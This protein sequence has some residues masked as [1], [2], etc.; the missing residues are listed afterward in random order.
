M[1]HELASKVLIWDLGFTLIEPNSFKI[2]RRLGI[3][4]CTLMYMTFGR[5]S[6]SIVSDSMYDVMMNGEEEYVACVPYD[7]E[8]RLM[9]L[10]MCEWIK[11]TRPNKEIQQDALKNANKYPDYVNDRH[12]RIIKRTISWMLNPSEFGTCMRP[13]YKASRLLKDCTR[14]KDKEGNQVHSMYILSNWDKESFDHL[15]KDPTNRPVFRHF[16]RENVYISGNFKDMKPHLPIFRHM[17]EKYNLDPAE[18]IFIDDQGDNV[19]AARAIG[20]KAIQ[21]RNGNYRDLRKKLKE[22]GVL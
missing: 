16:P 3:V 1:S 15:Y 9:P 20:M 22:F 21:V 14:R 19:R 11:S 7:P 12:K 17:V 10:C 2:A 5:A 8:G 6:H 13:M 4:D 18:C